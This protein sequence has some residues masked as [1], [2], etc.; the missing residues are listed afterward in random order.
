M[1]LSWSTVIEWK[2]HIWSRARLAATLKPL[3][4]AASCSDDVG[5]VDDH[6]EQDDVALIA[7]EF[8][9]SADQD[10]V[11]FAGGHVDA[12]VDEVLYES[13]LG[14]LAQDDDA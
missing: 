2:S 5:A 12:E 9:G 1:L 10:V 11:A 3:V 14:T 6:G 13:G 4:A 8:F 7:L